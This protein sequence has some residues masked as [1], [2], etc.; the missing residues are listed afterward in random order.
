MD[1]E[2][3][4]LRKSVRIVKHTDGEGQTPKENKDLLYC[5]TE[6][7]SKANPC[8]IKC[9]INGK[10]R[11]CLLDTGADV[12]PIYLK[13]VRQVDKL[14]R[15]AGL[16]RSASGKPLRI[17]GRYRDCT[18]TIRNKQIVCNPLVMENIG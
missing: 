15:Y 1:R 5:L 14:E 11:G 12:S 4:K 18:I 16:V 10:I 6:S 17:V 7:R 9:K 13:D 3:N 2:R 8:F